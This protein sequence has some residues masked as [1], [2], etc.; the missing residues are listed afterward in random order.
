MNQS[1]ERCTSRIALCQRGAMDSKTLTSRKR[2]LQA[3][4]SNRCMEVVANALARVPPWAWIAMTVVAAAAVAA[5]IAI[6]IAW[7]LAYSD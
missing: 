1:S 2:L 5:L 7:L 3:C 6:G 4:S